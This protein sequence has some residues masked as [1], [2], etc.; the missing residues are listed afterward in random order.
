MYSRH[1]CVCV[2]NMTGWNFHI[3][4]SAD[5]VSLIASGGGNSVCVTTTCLVRL[6][7]CVL[8]DLCLGL[9][10]WVLA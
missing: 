4:S 9:H 5:M 6:G 7:S 3:N 8:Y 2:Y 10:L 1:T